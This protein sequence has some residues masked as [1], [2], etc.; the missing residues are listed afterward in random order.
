M[1]IRKQEHFFRVSEYQMLY[2]FDSWQK[3]LKNFSRIQFWMI[4][5]KKT[6]SNIWYMY[7]NFHKIERKISINLSFSFFPCRQKILWPKLL[8]RHFRVFS[9]CIPKY[10]SRLNL[11]ESQFHF[12]AMNKDANF[13]RKCFELPQ[14]KCMQSLG[15]LN[16]ISCLWCSQ[17][18]NQQKYVRLLQNLISFSFHVFRWS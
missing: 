13:V 8:C 3:C 11:R 5:K 2:D 12:D 16:E 4:L 6:C 17:I 9:S 14:E 18:W 7:A 15:W 10:F 1:I